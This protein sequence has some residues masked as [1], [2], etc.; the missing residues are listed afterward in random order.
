MRI[1]VRLFSILRNCLPPDAEARGG[2]RGKATITLPDGATL[3]DLATHLAIDRYLG[4]AASELISRASWQVMVSGQFV[5]DMGRVLQ[6]G[7]EVYIF[8][9]ISGG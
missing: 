8:P 1:H 5:L 4:Y 9:P 2:S 3:T 6:D 7:D